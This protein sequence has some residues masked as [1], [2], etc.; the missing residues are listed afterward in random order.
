MLTIAREEQQIGLDDIELGEHDVERRV[1]HNAAVGSRVLF[2]C[3]I[4][5][6]GNDLMQRN[7]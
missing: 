1:E 5:T 2:E 3:Q 6:R 4:Q 7:W